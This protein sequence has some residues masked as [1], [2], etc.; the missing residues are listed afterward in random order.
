MIMR[1]ELPVIAA[2]ALAGLAGALAATRMLEAWLF[3]VAARDAVTLS[4]SVAI[5]AL[6]ALL[7]T[8]IP[9]LRAARLDP[10]RALRMD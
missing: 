5:L 10:L 4:V 2:G 3:G 6:V 9:A 7:A 1:A 8:W